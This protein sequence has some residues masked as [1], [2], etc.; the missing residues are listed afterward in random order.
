MLFFV[1]L[2]GFLCVFLG[3]RFIN[4]DLIFSF[5]FFPLMFFSVTVSTNEVPVY[6]SIGIK[7]CNYISDTAVV[8]E[9]WPIMF[10][11]ARA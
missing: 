3:G 8:A 11:L 5:S 4:F 7:L 2:L 1:F 9:Q 10:C 6:N